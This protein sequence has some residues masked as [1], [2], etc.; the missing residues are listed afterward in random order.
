MPPL[1]HVHAARCDFR[2]AHARL[3]PALTRCARSIRAAGP[4]SRSASDRLLRSSRARGGR[5]APIP[6][7]RSA[8]GCGRSVERD[9]ARRGFAPRPA[10]CSWVEQSVLEFR[11]KRVVGAATS[12]ATVR[13]YRER[14]RAQGRNRARSGRA[15]AKVRRLR[16]KSERFFFLHR[17][18]GG[19]VM[20]GGQTGGAEA[21]DSPW[22]RTARERVRRPPT[23]TVALRTSRRSPTFEGF[24]GGRG[25]GSGGGGRSRATGARVIELEGPS[26]APA[27]PRTNERLRCGRHAPRRTGRGS[28]SRGGLGPPPVFTV[29]VLEG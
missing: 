18:G 14:C 21:Q 2:P 12:C 16:G 27:P 28:R 29:T 4:A 3:A 25:S 17:L 5:G 22:M 10:P 20:H 8:L 23:S 1:A 24:E 13:A 11:E 9:L 7:V 19:V 15:S 26:A 6:G